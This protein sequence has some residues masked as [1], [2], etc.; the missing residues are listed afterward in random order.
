MYALFAYLSSPAVC[1][2]DTGLPVSGLERWIV[3]STGILDD[4]LVVCSA[5]TCRCL[6]REECCEYGP[7]AH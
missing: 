2:N 5:L 3:I 7:D 4:C 6:R 1:L